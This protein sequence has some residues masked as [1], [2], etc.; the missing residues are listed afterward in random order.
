MKLLKLFTEY[1][2]KKTDNYG[3]DGLYQP[4]EK[5]LDEGYQMVTE[6]NLKRTEEERDE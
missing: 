2:L 5:N 3:K 4:N 6:D 1:K